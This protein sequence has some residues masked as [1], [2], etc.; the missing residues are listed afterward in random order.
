VKDSIITKR[1]IYG[2]IVVVGSINMDLVVQAARAP[3][4]GETV[5]GSIFK[6][7]PGGKGANQAVASSLLGASTALVGCV[8]K[9]AFGPLLLAGLSEKKVD[10]SY[11][12]TLPEVATGTATIVVEESGENRII[13]VAGANGK[14]GKLEVEAAR[15]LISSARL[16][17]LQYEIPMETVTYVIEKAHTGGCTVV[18]NAAPAYPT[19][20]KLLTQ[21]DVLVVNETEAKMLSQVSVSDVQSAF[22][23]AQNL[24]AQGAKIVIVTLGAQGAILCSTKQHLHVPAIPVKVVDTT[25]AGDSFVGGF[26]ASLVKGRDLATALRFATCAGCLAVTRLGAQPSIPTE[27]EVNAILYQAQVHE[28]PQKGAGG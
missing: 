12:K 23:A 19:P 3:Q 5:S 16:V 11:V 7:I 8:G 25:A 1:A 21:I 6:L 28:L 22:L 2:D 14:V 13:V 26:A 24:Q 15:K 27:A 20:A 9:D 17:I 4:A 10:V 18:V